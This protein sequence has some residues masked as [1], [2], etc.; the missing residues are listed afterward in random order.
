MI[1][2]LEEISNIAQQLLAIAGNRRKWCFYGELGAGKTTLI[3]AIGQSLKLKEAV[4]SP[5]YSL[6][7]EYTYSNVEDQDIN[8]LYHL[9]LYRLQRIEEALDIG[10]EEYLYN[11]HFCFIEWAEVIAP[12]LPEDTFSVSISLLEDG[13]RLLTHR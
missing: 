2:R 10:I 1:Y 7:N 6:V 8:Y 5:T 9:D 11:E 4:T 12:I 13:R 3:K